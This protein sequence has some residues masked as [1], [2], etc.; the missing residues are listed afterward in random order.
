MLCHERC[1]IVIV[2]A[3]ILSI[4]CVLK[5]P[6]PRSIRNVH[7]DRIAYGARQNT[8]V[9]ISGSAASAIAPILWRCHIRCE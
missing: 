5:A 9:M 7:V 4:C 2:M 8:V 3:K 6:T 1:C